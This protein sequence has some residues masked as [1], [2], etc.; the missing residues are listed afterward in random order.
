MCKAI[1]QAKMLS[2]RFRTDRLLRHFTDN[3]EGICQACSS[4]EI[5]SIEHILLTCPS[6]ENHRLKLLGMIDQTDSLDETKSLIK[7][8]MSLLSN[9][10]V[11]L[12]L[13][14]SSMPEVIVLRQALGEKVLEDLFK[15]SRTWCYTINRERLKLLGR[16]R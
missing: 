11:Q 3:K 6:L 8:T 15:F 4:N 14:C 10:S 16:W 1:V 12:L 7:K 5:G 13:D 2:G 9:V